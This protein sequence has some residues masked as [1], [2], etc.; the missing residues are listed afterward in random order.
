MKAM[1]SDIYV[2]FAPASLR[3]IMN[4]NA[5]ISDAIA[6]TDMLKIQISR[7]CSMS[8]VVV[9]LI[10]GIIPVVVDDVEIVESIVEMG[11]LLVVVS[12]PVVVVEVSGL[13]RLNNSSSNTSQTP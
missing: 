3:R 13:Y 2:A 7:P 11:G 1:F 10:E 6:I 4:R 5:I 8:G 9:L 12:N